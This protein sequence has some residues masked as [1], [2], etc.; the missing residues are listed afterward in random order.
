[1]FCAMEDLTS[2]M[3]FQISDCHSHHDEIYLIFSSDLEK[4][5]ATIF[6]T[7]RRKY[8]LQCMSYANNK[9]AKQLCVVLALLVFTCPSFF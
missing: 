3:I 9:G 1:M 7:F 4:A 2:T 5:G 6:I 8:D